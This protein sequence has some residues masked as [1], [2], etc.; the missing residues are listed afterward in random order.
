MK[1]LLCYD[2]SSDSEAAI[3]VAG[4]L[5]AGAPTIV[6]TVWEGLSEVLVRAGAGLAGAPLD[7]E[8]V[9][10]QCEQGARERADAG[11]ALARGAGLNAEACAIRREGTIW[12]TILSAAT[13]NGAQLVVLGSRG[14][15]G[16]RA[17][18]LGS[19]SHAVLQHAQLPVLVVPA[20]SAGAG[21]DRNAL[22]QQAAV[23]V[24]PG[25]DLTPIH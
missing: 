8:A 12:E 7:F 4:E 1:I 15:T 6:L 23:A 22:A 20:A 18:L 5:F 13:S 3:K 24:R 14:L 9:D 25:S 19:V 2:G 10:A 17:L 21:P 16:V 11:V